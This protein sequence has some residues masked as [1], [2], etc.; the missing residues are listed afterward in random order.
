MGRKRKERM[1]AEKKAYLK[2]LHE[3][4]TEEEHEEE[5]VESVSVK[6]VEAVGQCNLK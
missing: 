4:P 2:S 5:P 1:S 6:K 3:Q